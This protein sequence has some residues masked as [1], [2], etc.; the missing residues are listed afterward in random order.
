[1]RETR[2]RQLQVG[3]QPEHPANSLC[4]HG[5]LKEGS[6]SVATLH[7]C[8][9]ARAYKT[10][11]CHA[12]WKQQHLHSMETAMPLHATPPGLR[13]AS[14]TAMS[15]TTAPWCAVRAYNLPFQKH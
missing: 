2:A 14:H 1:M 5:P 9:I 4:H 11:T 7:E 13:N 6:Q 8:T 10:L 15:W 12:G 3:I